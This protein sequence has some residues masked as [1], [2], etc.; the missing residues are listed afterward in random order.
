M[1]VN[2]TFP[3]AN[4]FVVG[5]KVTLSVTL[6]LAASV[7][8][9]VSP[10]TANSEPL[11]LIAEIVTLVSPLFVRAASCVSDWPAVTVPKRRLVGELINCCVAARAPKGARATMVRIVKMVT[12]IERG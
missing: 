12:R 11:R 3:P 1:L 4:P 9:R 8:G 5:E 2:V 6:S 7:T 10:D